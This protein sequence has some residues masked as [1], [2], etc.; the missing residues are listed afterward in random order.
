MHTAQSLVSL[1][2]AVYAKTDQEERANHLE[3]VLAEALHLYQT[4]DPGVRDPMQRALLAYPVCVM[5]ICQ[6]ATDRPKFDTI[7]KLLER[8]VEATVDDHQPLCVLAM[9]YRAMGFVLRAFQK[10]PTTPD[11]N[12]LSDAHVQFVGVSLMAER[13]LNDLYRASLAS[14]MIAQIYWQLGD[15]VQAT[16]AGGRTFRFMANAAR[17]ETMPMPHARRCLEVG[18]EFI[19]SM[20]EGK[21]PS[22]RPM[23]NLYC[24]GELLQTME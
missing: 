24:P 4:S 3:L 18:K 13:D 16:A 9:W 19:A 7:D 12:I 5:A 1:L 22:I 14:A 17:P 2:D 21:T 11:R 20:L 8:A 23:E 10:D 15:R 6:L